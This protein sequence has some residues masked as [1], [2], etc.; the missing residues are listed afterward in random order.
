V[1]VLVVGDRI[2]DH[3][4]FCS[5]QRVCPEAPALVLKPE[6]EKSSEG[7][8]ALVAAQLK[9]FLGKDKVMECYGTVSHKHRI[10]ADRQLVCRIDR[11]ITHETKLETY[12]KS[13]FTY[14]KRADA[15]VV[16]DYGKGSM[17]TSLSVALTEHCAA[18]KIPMFVDAKSDPDPYIGCFAIFPNQHEHDGI[19]KENYQHIVRKLGSKGCMVDGVM[20]STEEQYVYDVTGAGDIF[21][22]AFV[23]RYLLDDKDKK[24]LVVAARFANMV[25]GISVRH[26]G[27]YVVSKDECC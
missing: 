3:Y 19:S 11:D 15:V 5:P 23:Y 26:L 25:A 13:V 14:L 20:V 1:K 18:K 10:F 6:S 12:Y 4:T 8:A 24:D 27:T 21:L 17:Y 16:G 22:G 9:A 7:G 2:V